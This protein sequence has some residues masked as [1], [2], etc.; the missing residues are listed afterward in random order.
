[1]TT[2]KRSILSAVALTA[3]CLVAAAQT[4]ADPLVLTI[5]NPN[6]TV[7]PGTWIT[8]TGTLTNSSPLGFDI[9]N[10]GISYPDGLIYPL[11]VIPPNFIP[12]A[13]PLSTVSG[14]ILSVQI[15]PTAVPGAYYA[16]VNLSGFFDNGSINGAGCGVNITVTNPSSVPE[17]TSM[18]LFGTGL[19]SAAGLT[20]RYRK[21]LL[22]SVT[23]RKA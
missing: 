22:R 23:F 5:D 18:I 14:G 9:R 19:I 11:I 16:T 6:Q 13:G 17:P 21:R 12:D 8:F 2:L 10:P 4:N 7:T 1:M 20:R 3:I 15:S